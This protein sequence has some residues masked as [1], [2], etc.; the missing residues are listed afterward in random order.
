MCGP[1]HDL[2]FLRVPLCRL[3]SIKAG[4][5]ATRVKLISILRRQ[6]QR[7]LCLGSKSYTI[8]HDLH[9]LPI[10]P[11]ITTGT[12]VQYF[13]ESTSIDTPILPR[14]QRL[15]GCCCLRAENTSHNERYVTPNPSFLLLWAFDNSPQT[16][17]AVHTTSCNTETTTHTKVRLIN[18]FLQIFYDSVFSKASR[19][20]IRIYGA[21]S[22]QTLSA[23]VP[24]ILLSHLMW[25]QV[26]SLVGLHPFTSVLLSVVLFS[27]FL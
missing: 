6:T 22:P 7:P 24:G 10:K 5:A 21:V 23:T 8:Q 9:T 18:S 20:N 25:F 3:L 1:V 13:Q 19:I 12:K 2:H 27:Y 26:N 17:K 11:A 16:P 4:A 14:R 15:I